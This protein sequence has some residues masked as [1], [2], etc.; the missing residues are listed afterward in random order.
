MHL[1]FAKLRS[2]ESDITNIT[3]DFRDMKIEKKINFNTSTILP[4]KKKRYCF[5]K[6]NLIEYISLAKQ[7]NQQHD[8]KLFFNNL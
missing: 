2:T 4:S 3:L 7:K 5:G 8:L 1:K 6:C